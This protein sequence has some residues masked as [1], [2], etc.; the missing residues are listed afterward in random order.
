MVSQNNIKQLKYRLFA[1]ILSVIVAFVSLS[2]ATY[3]WYVSNNKVE[4]RA[5]SIA[6]EANG[7][8]LQIVKYGESLDHGSDQALYSATNGHKISPASP[9]NFKNWWIPKEW[10]SGMKVSS[11]M[12]PTWDKDDKGNTL[13]GQYTAENGEVYYTH[14]VAAYTLYTLTNTGTCDV[15]LDGSA[16]GGAIQV[17]VKDQD[18][19]S[20]AVSDKVAASIRV[21]LSV[22]DGDDEHLV[23][24][25]APVNPTGKGNDVNATEGW[26]VVADET[27]TKLA[28]YPHISE[29][30]YEWTDNGVTKNFAVTKDGLN[31]VKG[32]NAT[33]LTEANYEGVPLRV[34]VWLE[35]TDADCISSVVDG[36]NRVFN[37]TLHLAGVTKTSAS[38]TPSN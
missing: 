7:F 4:G 1:S 14:V 9:E 8:M 17:T 21:G 28:S 23:L 31:Y 3:A 16:D 13:I 22:G 24:V 35:G 30:N 36:D 12:Y 10:T 11:Y 37:V 38:N 18:N 32:N 2:S 20:V 29:T 15:F 34:Y 6:A 27:S 5:T 26:S 33:P 25:Y 19:K